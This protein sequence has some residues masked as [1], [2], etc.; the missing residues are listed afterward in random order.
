[1]KFSIGYQLPDADDSIYEII[2]DYR[3]S[4]SSVYFSMAGQASARS[5]IEAEAG[6]DMIE[7]LRAIND[8][9]VPAT[10]LYNANCYG[11]K[12]ISAAFRDEIILMVGNLADKLDLR[13]ITT[14]SP[15]VAKVIKENFPDIKVCASVNMWIGTPQAMEYLGDNFD[16]YYLQ[17]EYNRDFSHIRRMKAWCDEHGKH[18]KLLANSGCLYA[19]AFHSFHDNMVA[20][21]TEIAEYGN[22]FSNYPSPCWDYMHTLKS[23]EAAATFLRGSWIR[24]EDTANYEPYISE[25][26]LATRMHS[27]PRRVVMA[28]A[29][30]RFRGN[31]FDLTEPSYSRRFSAHI[32]DAEKFP[33]DWF[34]RTTSC[35]RNCESCTYCSDVAGK[36]LTEKF[37]LEEM[38][39]SKAGE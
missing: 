14:T 11:G 27:N 13:E 39:C 30:G 25:M 12:A 23:K 28:Y 9:G 5:A 1:M 24:P 10:L 17:R 18:L 26:K 2:R 8:M 20:H 32:L 38:F 37:A 3:E 4:I 19:C 15:F 36:M 29:R 6:N 7:E 22:V 35:K 21:E 33:R 31:M 16:A 34:E